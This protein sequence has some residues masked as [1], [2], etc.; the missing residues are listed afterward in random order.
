MGILYI[1]KD[2]RFIAYQEEINKVIFIN[3]VKFT[4]NKKTNGCKLVSY[5]QRDI[6]L[7]LLILIKIY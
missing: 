2:V 3:I 5:R 7:Q 6:S 1:S 4:I